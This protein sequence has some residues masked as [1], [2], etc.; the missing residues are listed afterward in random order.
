MPPGAHPP[1]WDPG[2]EAWSRACPVVGM[3]QTPGTFLPPLHAFCGLARLT[4]ALRNV[5]WAGEIPSPP[6]STQS[7]AR[8]P[9]LLSA[10]LGSVSR[11][12]DPGPQPERGE[13]PVGPPSLC[14]L[15]LSQL[16]DP[17]QKHP[18]SPAIPPYPAT[19]NSSSWPSGALG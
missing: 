16:S 4:G 7:P 1:P 6:P 13:G 18:S 5:A 11:H 3:C 8:L 15:A 12:Q 19:W 17:P 14:G 2:Q 9:A 10:G